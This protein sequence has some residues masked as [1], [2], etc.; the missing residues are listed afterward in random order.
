MSGRAMGHAP[1]EVKIRHIANCLKAEPDY[2]KG[3]AAM[4]GFP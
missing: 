3:A 2:G 4:L 1:R